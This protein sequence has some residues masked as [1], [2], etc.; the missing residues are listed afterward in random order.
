MRFRPN[1]DA[2]FMPKTP[3]EVFAAGEQNDVPLLIGFTRDESSNDLR[4]A[5]NAAQF[6]EAAQ[7]VFR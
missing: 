2:H 7:E 3:R 4:T 5:H 6:R 1:L